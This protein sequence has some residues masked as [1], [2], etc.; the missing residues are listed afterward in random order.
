MVTPSTLVVSM[1][2]LGPVKM[3]ARAVEVSPPTPPSSYLVILCLIPLPLHGIL[4]WPK[5]TYTTIHCIINCIISRAIHRHYVCS[6]LAAIR[7][8]T[9]SLGVAQVDLHHILIA[10]IARQYCKQ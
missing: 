1:P 4:H 10:T 9:H 3:H 2:S 7:D 5:G 6:K 8:T